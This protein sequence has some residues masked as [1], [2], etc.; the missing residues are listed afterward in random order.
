MDGVLQTDEHTRAVL[1]EAACHTDNYAISRNTPFVIYGARVFR[2]G[3]MWCALLGDNIQEG[4][5]AFAATPDKAV[6]EF[7]KVWYQ[8]VAETYPK[9]ST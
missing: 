8:T 5:C 3:N 7:N 2:D 6:Q 9:Q 1:H 4:V